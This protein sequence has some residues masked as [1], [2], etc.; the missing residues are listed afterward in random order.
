MQR[1]STILTL[2]CL[3]HGML[4]GQMINGTDTLYGNEW[5]DYAQTYYRVKVAQDGIYRIGYQQ[6]LDQGVPLA[7]ISGA[8]L[9][10]YRYGKQVP[11]F[12]SASGVL[13][14]GDYVEFYGERNRDAIDRY[15][16]TDP[17]GEN[18]NPW[19]SLFN[20]TTTYYLAWQNAGTGE[21]FQLINNDLNNL[22][23]KEPYCWGTNTVSFQDQAF[24]RS[25]GFDVAYSWYDGDGFGQQ[26]AT[27]SLVNVA[28]PQA[29]AG[30][31]A[32]SVYLRYGCNL[33]QHETQIKLNDSIFDL[34]VINTFRV[35]GHTYTVPSG[36]LSQGLN[37]SLQSQGGQTDRHTLVGAELRYARTFDFGGAGSAVFELE[38]SAGG[39]Y[40]EI[41]GINLAAGQTPVLYDLTN[42]LRLEPAVQGD[43]LRVKLPPSNV[44]RRI[45]VAGVPGG[46]T[47]VGTLSPIQFHDYSSEAATYVLISNSALWQDPAN[48]NAN[49]VQEYA[50]YRASMAGGSFNTTIVDINE[51]YEQFAYGIR[52]H[53][54]SIR[55]FCY[56]LKKINPVSR[57][58]L[59]I[60][61]GLD[62]KDFRTQQAQSSL[63]ET[64][65]FLPNYGSP[66]S[67]LEYVMSGNRITA[68]IF[69]IG[70][71]AVT[72]PS[73]IR[74]YLDKVIEQEQVVS[75]AQQTIEDKAWL[76]KALHI[77]GGL[78][79]EQASIKSYVQSMTDEI[80]ANGFG[81]QV[82]TFYKTSNDPIQLTAF[83]RVKQSVNEGLSTWMIFG[84]SSPFLVDFDIGAPENYQN[85]GRY[86][87]MFIMGCFSGN[88]SYPIKGL[89]E[90]FVL[91]RDKGVIAYLAPVNYGFTDALHSF[92]KRF[93][94]RMG[95]AD[96]GNS[97]GQTI[98]HTISSFDATTY[99]SLVALL[100]QM[101]LQGD[102]AVRLH[103][104][105][106][107][108]Y[109]IDPN[110]VVIDPNPVSIDRS[111]FDVNFSLANIGRNTGG[112][113]GL[114]ISQ[115]LP[116]NSYR[117]LV[118]DSVDAPAFRRAMHYTI[119]STDNKVGYS[120]LFI[121]AD[122]D[123]LV[124]ETPATAE[125]N[126]EI[127][128]A[129]GER[130]ME[131]YFYTDDV[132]PVLPEHF[133]I[134]N[135]TP[136]RLYASSLA[137]RNNPL[138]YL[139][140]IDTTQVFDSPLRVS[141]EI[142]GKSGLLHWDPVIPMIDST[143][144][145]WRVARDSLVGGSVAWHGSSFMYIKDSPKGWNQSHFGQ[146]TQ[147]AF[148]TM[149]LNNPQDG[150]Q[151]GDDAASFS[152]NVA[153]RNV[154]AEISPGLMNNFSEGIVTHYWWNVVG[155]QRGVVI[156]QYNPNTGHFIP[157]PAG[158]PTNPTPDADNIAFWFDTRDSLER[159]KLMEFLE[160]GMEPGA[161]AGLLTVNYDTD[162]EGY[163]PRKWAADSITYGKNLFQV[164][165]N[166]G[167][168][169]IRKVQNSPDPPYPY[170]M[171]FRVGDA[172]FAVWDTVVY[173][174]DSLINFRQDFS[175]K[176]HSGAVESPRIGPAASW[177]SVHW[178]KGAYDDPTERAGLT[179]LGVR[180]N[181][182]D[183]VLFRL[184][185]TFDTSLTDISAATFPYLKIR[186]EAVD[187]TN[188]TATQLEY[189]RVLYQ[190]VPEGALNPSAQFTF[191]RDTL[192]QG[193]AMKSAIAFTNISD[194]PM[195]SVLVR[196]RVETANG[197]GNNYF[198]QYKPL[199]PG[200]TLLTSFE[201]ST[202]ALQ[203]KQRLTVDINPDKDQPE[204]YHFNNVAF[205]DFYVQRDNR[206]PLLDVTFDGL[207]I[208]DGDLI[209]PKPEV[210]ITLKDDNRFLAMRDTSTFRL[211]LELPD[212]STQPIA[213]NDQALLFF[214]ADSIN[215]D[216]KNQARLEWR[217]GFIQDGTY[218]LLVNGRDASGNLSASLDYAV[219]FEVITRSSL[220]HIFNYPNPFSTSTCFVYTMTGA[221]TPA[222]FKIQIMT[223][224]GR[225][226][227]EI[228]TAE[229]GDLHAGTHISN[230]CWD[231][232]DE[233]GDQLAN[234]VYLY[235]V[236]AKKMDGSDFEL[237]TN[238]KA[239]GFFKHGF[240]KMVLMR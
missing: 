194:W 77:S 115:H 226:V 240:G 210:I 83:E 195:D 236:V 19:Y 51:L 20:D 145:Y 29:I 143:V 112:K 191:Y 125:F 188:R 171:V 40:L 55:N 185:T 233:F 152:M 190:G 66:G 18:L 39:Q 215:L 33:G 8:D 182:P 88:C 186:Y 211:T 213:Q 78:A 73:E 162:L 17:N 232:K 166:M 50:E 99:P 41:A 25:R 67:D 151:F 199:A 155:V 13:G 141:G 123:D 28:A 154:P 135:R 65:Y 214:P 216:H 70:R 174:P 122:P 235:R 91:V 36:F 164:L 6:M 146:F 121:E 184:N 56:Y 118:K 86:P 212:G 59:L 24:K 227:R 80:T 156:F 205:S 208:M 106:G 44:K 15:L 101:Q 133:G 98:V 54:F 4:S 207:H 69:P 157:N 95:G 148:T 168:K 180:E 179:V 75:S 225:V 57:Y 161:Y 109:L 128:D 42:R 136:L 76:K 22:P 7:T 49:Y 231:G 87:L 219:S 27:S 150:F 116:D 163:A 11:L 206:N 203:G 108:D 177:A 82:Q 10:L 134:V 140:E 234:G 176:W 34:D 37:I 90:N 32:A 159:I 103:R 117:L 220:S 58:V 114:K 113:I 149:E 200:D 45:Y 5:I 201:L 165:E 169:D 85:K 68:P 222:S 120:R 131:L 81:A 223:V 92:G 224:S 175:A 35:T 43:L 132:Q 127:Q 9:R 124:Q 94:E 14:N 239:D 107:P 142:S 93:Y 202:Q 1:F 79:D 172:G 158:S 3:S 16:F 130:G 138:H 97:L 89:G 26:E 228:T 170:G 64:V 74:A 237:F 189:A 52:Y 60:G 160:N 193:D 173:H 196:Y 62:Y 144:Y 47:Q 105:Q 110:S 12:V 96:Y 63:L 198:K 30:G 46:I 53:P 147:D 137:I 119:P 178:K 111:S 61:K 218:R 197:V 221:E 38:A 102:P 129:N 229:F 2:I 167:A 84:H 153:Y 126:N 217:P 48:G 23:A 139:F 104:N 183:T 204:L 71:L 230:F 72:Q 192:Q 21:R 100:H 209:S 31:P 238:E 187:S 181:L